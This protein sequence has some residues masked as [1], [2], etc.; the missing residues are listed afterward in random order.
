M[1]I[2]LT[3]EFHALY[4][5][6]HKR[7]LEAVPLGYELRFIGDRKPTW[8][9]RLRA[10]LYTGLWFGVFMRDREYIHLDVLEEA[11]LCFAIIESIKKNI[12]NWAVDAHTMFRKTGDLQIWIANG[13]EF[14]R[15]YQPP[16]PHIAFRVWSQRRLMRAYRRVKKHMKSHP[17]FSARAL[18]AHLEHS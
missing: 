15:T 17:S 9:D 8:L 1:G 16:S 4:S 2:K 11:A 10:R 13:R 5:E 12:D 6:E 18:I 7:M 3:S 14:V